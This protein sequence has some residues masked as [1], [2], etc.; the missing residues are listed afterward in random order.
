[1]SCET[2]ILTQVKL[3]RDGS[4]ASGPEIGKLSTPKASLGS[5]SC[6]AAIRADRKAS[7]PSAFDLIEGAAVCALASASLK[8]SGPASAGWMPIIVAQQP[9]THAARLTVISIGIIPETRVHMARG[10]AREVPSRVHS[11]RTCRNQARI[12]GGSGSGAVER[13]CN[14]ATIAACSNCAR[15]ITKGSGADPSASI[16]DTPDVIIAMHPAGPHLHG[17]GVEC[18]IIDAMQS[19]NADMSA[20]DIAAMSIGDVAEANARAGC[21]N[22]KPKIMPKQN[23][24]VAIRCMTVSC[25]ASIWLSTIGLILACMPGWQQRRNSR[26]CKVS[27]GSTT[28]G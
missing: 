28:G 5:G 24:R 25:E 13:P 3:S 20:C 4:K 17:L 27:F 16:I 10:P 14:A 1:M 8:V 26:C 2:P 18:F 7:A 11:T 12:E 19:G 22:D 9:H 21:C 23:S 6:P 15:A